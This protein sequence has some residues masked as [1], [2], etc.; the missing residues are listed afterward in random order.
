MMSGV[1]Q[2]PLPIAATMAEARAFL[3]MGAGVDDAVLAGLLRSTTA[4]CEQ[5]IGT[6][7]VS[8]EV[9]ETLPITG[10]WQRLSLFPVTAITSLE[11]I[12]AEGA[13]FAFAVTDY[14]IDI[15]SN[16]AGWVKIARQGAAG[17][18]RITYRA[19]LAASAGEVPDSLRQGIIMAAAQLHRLRDG[20]SENG[21]AVPVE[22]RAL[23][24]PYRRMR[25]K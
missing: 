4:L 5:T 14:A 22:A 3:R 9:R 1:E 24:Q 13:L 11:G 8:R 19:G 20:D 6:A 7:L 15:D 17:R 16:G 10:A 21:G 2:G 23:W 18:V 25:L 12:P